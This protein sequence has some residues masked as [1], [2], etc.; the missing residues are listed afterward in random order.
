VHLFK[1]R[2]GYR[3]RTNPN[4]YGPMIEYFLPS[5]PD[6]AVTMD[7]LDA[8]GAVVNSYNSDAPVAAAGGGGRGGRGGGGGGG[9]AAGAGAAA[10]GGADVAGGAVTPPPPPDP[11]A[12]GGGGGGGFGGRGGGGG[13]VQTRVTKVIGMNRVVWNVQYAAGVQAPPGSYQVRL[14]VNGQAQTQPFTVLID[15]NQ[16]AEGLTAADLQEEF[17]HNAKMR[18]LVAD[19]NATLARVRAGLASADAAK[20]PQLQVIYEQIVATPE[21]VRYNKPGLQEH[22]NYLAGMTRGDQK[23]GHDAVERYNTLKKQ[24]DDIKAQLDKILGPG[25]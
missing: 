17:D 20:K 4:L 18:A 10:G 14:T 6:G 3:T 19:V 9:R 23:V 12:G 7:M 8:K 15:P 25:K 22:A 21:G 13:G 5:A 1:P 11:E 24:L 2:D 16:A